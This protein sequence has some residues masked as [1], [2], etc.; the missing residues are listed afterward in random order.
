ML[1]IAK[2]ATLF[3]LIIS[4]GATSHCLAALMDFEVNEVRT[5][6]MTEGSA[7]WECTL[8][9]LGT[10][11]LGSQTYFNVLQT[12]YDQGS[13]RTLY[14]RSTQSEIFMY[15]GGSEFLIFQTGNLGDEW[16]WTDGDGVGHRRQIVGVGKYVTVPYGS[17]PAYIYESYRDD[18]DDGLQPYQRHFVTDGIGFLYESD[19]FSGDPSNP[20]IQALSEINSVPVPGAILLLGSGLLGIV[21]WRRW[22]P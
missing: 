3:F 1:S 18:I 8:E 20:H 4:L 22:L 14:L 21:G 17:F 11:I 6:Q 5:Y 12:G 19:W 7:S 10:E 2:K 15:E 13:T 16:H 9:T